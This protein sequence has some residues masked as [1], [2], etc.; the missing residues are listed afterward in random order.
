[1]SDIR[2][3]VRQH[4][5]FN[6]HDHQQG[7]AEIERG[8]DQY[9]FKSLFGY[10][11][12]DLNCAAGRDVDVEQLSRDELAELWRAVRLT[13][14]GRAVDLMSRALFD[15]PFAPENWDAITAALQARIAIKSGAEIY[16][17]F[18]AA[19]QIKWTINDCFWAPVE[20]WCATIAQHPD[21]YR[22]T[23][24]RD[25][26]FS[27]ADLTPV[28]EIGRLLGRHIHSA[29]ALVAALNDA[30]S[31]YRASGKLAAIKIGMAYQRDLH[32]SDPT[33]HEAELAFNRL[34]N[35][36]AFVGGMQQRSGAVNARE[37]RPLGDYLLQRLFERAADD[38]I[39]VQ[40]H[41]GYLA[42]NWG[43][44]EATRAMQLLPVLDKFRS[45]R[46]DLFHASWPWCSELG[47]IAKEFPNVWPDLCWMWTMNPIEAE[48]ALDGWL[49][50]VPFT[51]IFGF[52]SDTGLPW[53]DIGYALQAKEGVANVLE[54]KIAAGAY[55][56][57]DAREVADHIL[58]LNGEQFFGLA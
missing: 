44:L 3:Y 2:D 34:R 40:I 21:S 58:L 17:D 14:Y 23:F 50:G 33:L 9:D 46:F 20:D 13:G 4:A 11:H 56:P 53:C 49:D 6:H 51:K 55:S 32:I 15:L 43:A 1:M 30:I 39:P 38:D 18:L 5:L 7:Y 24:R 37:G 25:E 41:T 29:P 31:S 42:G 12:A 45:V 36:D 47:T 8:R 22:F 10:L 26:L 57:A 52:G 27:L 19:A 16:A 54:R 35:L 48:H 28:D